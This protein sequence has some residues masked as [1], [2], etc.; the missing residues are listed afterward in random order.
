MQ[1]K[2]THIRVILTAI[3]SL[4]LY[5]QPG[6]F[7]ARA[8]SAS[9]FFTPSVEPLEI[10]STPV[11]LAPQK[12]DPAGKS[13]TTPKGIAGESTG[14][15]YPG[16]MYTSAAELPVLTGRLGREEF[17]LGSVAGREDLV[18]VWMTRDG[19]TRYLLVSADNRALYG[20]RDPV[21]DNPIGNGFIYRLEDWETLRQKRVE[22]MAESAGSVSIAVGT[23]AAALGELAVTSPAGIIAGLTGVFDIF[24]GFIERYV[25]GGYTYFAMKDVEQDLAN[26]FDEAY[27]L[28]IRTTGDP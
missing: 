4:L 7:P 13:P 9:V 15:L 1:L 26:L 6:Y 25:V 19:E 23:G 2:R 8:S 27:Q 14:S 28:E 10:E 5:C 18:A 3:L 22:I 21:T 17:G 24:G 16:Q 12:A 20:I 11:P